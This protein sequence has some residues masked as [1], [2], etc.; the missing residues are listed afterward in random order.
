MNQLSR[1]KRFFRTK[2]LL[3]S[4]LVLT[5]YVNAGTGT[6]V[7]LLASALI[8]SGTC[9]RA[10]Q[11]S[12][13]GAALLPRCLR[14]T[15]ASGTCRRARQLSATGTA[16]LPRSTVSRPY[17]NLVINADAS[18]EV[19]ATSNHGRGAKKIRR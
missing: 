10:R 9:R 16:L 11:L 14:R 18:F 1:L 7:R 12:A 8:A 4:T 5:K 19:C 13:A 6:V 2:V 3:N 17:A 15:V